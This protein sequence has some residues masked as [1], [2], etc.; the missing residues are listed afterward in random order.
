[1]CKYA[2]QLKEGA[3]MYHNAVCAYACPQACEKHVGYVGK[4]QSTIARWRYGYI[5]CRYL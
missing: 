2:A 1:M 5:Y 4:L 3:G